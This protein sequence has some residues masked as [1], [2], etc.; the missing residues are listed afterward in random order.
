MKIAVSFLSCKKI[1]KAIQKIDYTD[2]DYVHVDVVD[3]R[4][5]KGR[6]IS[7]R[8]LKKMNTLTSK[9]LDV[10]LM[11]KK[12]KKYIE[13]LALLNVE[14]IVFHVETMKNIDTNL[15]YIHSFG[16][17]NGLAINPNTDVEILRPF[18]DKID[19]ILVMSVFPGYGG[20]AF[21]EETIERV[22]AIRKM[23]DE[24]GNKILLAV[25]GGIK[26]NEAAN[27]TKADMIISG[28]FITESDNYQEQINKLRKVSVREVEYSQEDVLDQIKKDLEKVK[29]DKPKKRIT[30]VSK[31]EPKEK[32]VK[33]TKE[34]KKATKKDEKKE[35]KE[36]KTTKKE[37]KT[38]ES[39]KT[40]TKTKKEK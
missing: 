38:K 29:E 12:P 26:L 2:A 25:D 9:R 4:F 23:I 24:S 15:S 33:E 30:K 5:V 19:T 6:K 14:R 13:K 21:I 39:T 40:K 27:L 34:A 22:E 37:T 28:S 17:K 31:K 36:K 32:K 1:N 10:H 8:K 18:L 16:V 35:V 3:N 20:Q 7:V 11:V